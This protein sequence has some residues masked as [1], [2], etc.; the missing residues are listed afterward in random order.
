MAD[1]YRGELGD[2]VVRQMCLAHLLRDATYAIDEGD[3]RFAL[4]FRFLLCGLWR[5]VG[6]ATN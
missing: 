2:G 6:D 4:G 1:R 5:L 3:H